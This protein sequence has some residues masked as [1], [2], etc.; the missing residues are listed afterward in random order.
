MAADK[1]AATEVELYI[2]LEHLEAVAIEPWLSAPQHLHSQAQ[3]RPIHLESAI[4]SDRQ[5]KT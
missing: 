2:M 5:N 4:D 1:L 3:P